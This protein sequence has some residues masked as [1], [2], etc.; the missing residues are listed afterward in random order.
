[1]N[2]YRQL[3]TALS[4]SE[5]EKIS[6]S[7][8]TPIEERVFRVLISDTGSQNEAELVKGLGLTRSHFQKTCSVLLQKAYTVLEPRGGKYLL[9]YL[10]RKSIPHIYYAEVL[11]QEKII[12]PLLSPEDRENFYFIAFHYSTACPIDDKCLAKMQFYGKKY[13]SAIVKKHPFD[14]LA[15]E[16]RCAEYKFFSDDTNAEI[17]AAEV[18]EYYS[19]LLSVKKKLGRSRHRLAW[20]YL[21]LGFMGYHQ[22]FSHSTEDYLHSID[23]LQ[24]WRPK[25]IEE[26][27]PENKLF[28]LVLKGK[29]LTE[30]QKYEQAFP[31]LLEA[32][33]KTT[34]PY[35]PLTS[36]T[37]II[38]AI[39]T[40]HYSKAE[41]ILSQLLASP[42]Q[43]SYEQ[44]FCYMSLIQCS[45]LQGRYKAVPH[46]FAEIY[47]QNG[48][49]YNEAD[50]IIIRIYETIFSFLQ[51][52][53]VTAETV[54]KKN[55]Q[56][57]NRRKNLDRLSGEKHLLQSLKE[58]LSNYWQKKSFLLEFNNDLSYIDIHQP[59]FYKIM[60]E[61]I[62]QRLKKMG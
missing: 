49:L 30:G 9:R 12:A 55:I 2:N 29:A 43:Y 50:D 45:L 48:I 59:F 31:I 3:L 20:F 42:T 25:L 5:K 46:L 47:R 58:C 53:L 4:T 23:Q 8:F 61:R 54:A 33:E 15:V 19:Y 36:K 37:F 27:S 16:L 57:L 21:S 18:E 22:R 38:S 11:R 1:M 51:D 60:L 17:N 32:I 13:L 35:P 52:D 34:Y 40:G 28:D 10:A 7:H 56:W 6:S 24:Y 44:T 14:S 26:V 39:N 41:H 62:K